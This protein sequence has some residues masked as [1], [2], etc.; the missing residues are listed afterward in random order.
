MARYVN[1]IASRGSVFQLS[2]IKGVVDKNGNFIENEA[3][4]ENKV[5]LADSTWE[6]V[7]SGM[8]QFAQN[9]SVLRDMEISIAGKTGTAQ[10]S[11][12]RPDHALYVVLHIYLWVCSLCTS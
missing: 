11:K 9:N 6:T 5:E 2:L 12:R 3:V 7:N 1:T 4:L 10:E 8:V